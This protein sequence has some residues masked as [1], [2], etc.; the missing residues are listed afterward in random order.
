MIELRRALGKTAQLFFWSGERTMTKTEY[1]VYWFLVILSA[2]T[3]ALPFMIQV[4]RLLGTHLTYVLLPLRRVLSIIG[5]SNTGM[6]WL[7]LI[8]PFVAAP[9]LTAIGVGFTLHLQRRVPLS[10]KQI[11]SKPTLRAFVLCGIAW[12]FVLISF[13][14]LPLFANQ[15]SLR[16]GVFDAWFDYLF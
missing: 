2:I 5:L 9:I 15:S 7:V 1:R 6:L 3:T 14:L 16:R 8:V 13:R 10:A 4:D 11:H 12:L